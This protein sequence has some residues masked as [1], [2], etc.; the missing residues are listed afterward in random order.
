VAPGGPDASAFRGTVAQPVDHRVGTTDSARD[1]L[2]LRF[3]V[4]HSSGP[5]RM[6]AL[7]N[8]GRLLVLPGAYDAL[9]ARIVEAAGFEA[10]YLSGPGVSASHLG[11]P[12]LGVLTATDMET[13][14][15]HV[16]QAV[17]TPVIVDVDTGYGGP[18][19]VHAT[20]MTLEGAG[21]A[22]LHLE[23]Q[24]IPKRC[25]HYEGKHLVD[26]QTMVGK[27]RMAVDARRDPDF[28]VIGRTDAVAVEGL[29]AAIERCQAYLAA[30]AD[31]VF[32]DALR[33]VPAIEK[34]AAAVPGPK[35]L[36]LG[37]YRREPLTPRVEFGRLEEMGY[38][39][40]ILPL[41]ILRAAARA[42][43]DLAAGLRQF[44]IAAESTFIREVSD[45]PVGDWYR[46]LGLDEYEQVEARYV[47]S[48]G[49]TGS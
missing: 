23:D 42:A 29:E 6:R 2:L 10:V 4:T 8:Q 36:T 15:R 46:F 40:V 25:G 3:E 5:A 14:A 19:N 7:L 1:R 35:A 37:G 38:Q 17:S 49:D 44:G 22:G 43:W 31:L 16:V 30:G 34:F 9:S 48:S 20:T 33:T 26:P 39:I 21:V 27:I 45:H 11:V 13:V 32:A 24:A 12:D 41:A 18:F 47:P 28:L